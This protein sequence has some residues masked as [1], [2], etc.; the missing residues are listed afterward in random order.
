MS[1]TRNDKVKPAGTSI[2]ADMKIFPRNLTARAAYVVRGN[3]VV[4]RPESGADNSH[5][6][7]EFDQRNI[8]RGFFPGLLF[9]FHFD[10]GARLTKVFSPWLE[11]EK[12]QDNRNDLEARPRDFCL[13]YVCGRFGDQADD[14]TIADLYGLD[15][16]DVLRRVHD[17]EPG[18]LAIVIGL[19]PERMKLDQAWLAVAKKDLLPLVAPLMAKPEERKE[20][21]RALEEQLAGQERLVTFRDGQGNL[22]GAVLVSAR[23]SYLNGEGVIDLQVAEPGAL[24]QSLCSPWQWDFQDC[25]CYY[26]AASRPDIVTASGGNGKPQKVNFL[27]KRPDSQPAGGASDSAPSIP[28]S[29]SAW[30]DANS[31][32]SQPWMLQGWES[33]PLVI[34]DRE[35]TR[36]EAGPPPSMTDLWDRR[37]VVDQLKHLAAVEHAL[38]VKFLYAHYSVKVADDKPELAEVAH[39]VRSIAIDEMHHFRWV[40]EALQMLRTTPVFDRA[41][42]LSAPPGGFKKQQYQTDLTLEALTPES[43]QRF[44]EIERPSR[45]DDPDEIAGLY[46]HILLSLQNHQD[47][48]TEYPADVCQRLQEIVKLIIDEGGEHFYRMERVQESLQRLAPE[49]YL[50]F[51]GPPSAQSPDSEW[52]RLQILGDHYYQLLLEA[53]EQAF[54]EPPQ[55]R[56]EMIGQARRV[57]H[58]LDEVGRLLA[59][60]GQGLLFTMPR[61]PRR[62]GSLCARVS[63]T[64]ET[65]VMRLL[66]QLRRSGSP[67]VHAFAARHQQIAGEMQLFFSAKAGASR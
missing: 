61:S 27:R 1:E 6:G 55:T 9:D 4:S 57:M 11:L 47:R 44:I 2:P 49:Q 58:N 13:W 28:L 14:L 51:S 60:Q 42:K 16:Y 21:L 35:T 17:L 31:I 54:L 24:T 56:G 38:C 63:R 8:D 19:D 22:Q 18:P 62:G 36:F 67:E 46:T 29:W 33:L 37:T 48:K 5:P 30:M 52:G 32:V 45:K 10:T 50:A 64:L 40:N 12:T 53:L 25:G 59:R 34:D 23:A 15:S 26:W 66:A 3:P 41:D 7:L 39:E 43:V 20:A 65:A